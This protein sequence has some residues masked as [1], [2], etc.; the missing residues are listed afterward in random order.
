MNLHKE[1]VCM[2][3]NLALDFLKSCTNPATLD[4]GNSQKY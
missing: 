2:A 1:N 4:K 3:E